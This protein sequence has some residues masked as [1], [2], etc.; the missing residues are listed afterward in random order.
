[1]TADTFNAG[2]RRRN[3]SGWGVP[4]VSD[5]HQGG[6]TST[7][8]V[9]GDTATF[10]D[11]GNLY[12]GVFNSTRQFT[13]L[14]E[15]FGTVLDANDAALSV[16][17]LGRGDVVGTKLWETPWFRSS[18]GARRRIREDVRQ[19]Q[20]GEVVSGERAIVGTTPTAHS[21]SIRPILDE[22][23]NAVFL[24]VEAHEIPETRDVENPEL[25]PE[26]EPG[27]RERT[28]D[29]RVSTTRAFSSSDVRDSG[30]DVRDFERNRSVPDSVEGE[31]HS[32]ESDTAGPRGTARLLERIGA[33]ATILG[34]VMA[35]GYA[36]LFARGTD[37]IGPVQRQLHNYFGSR[38][39]EPFANLSPDPLGGLVAAGLVAVAGCCLLLGVRLGRRPF[40]EREIPR[41]GNNQ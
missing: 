27:H 38:W 39:F 7:S 35:T 16:G 5:R 10:G 23:G 34:T 9:P 8:L 33:V 25:E 19:A 30:S 36:W 20:D 40:S 17:N 22:A 26:P 3:P 37:A 12:E 15:H 31:E 24:V 29:D 13:C 4:T 11:A 1:M 18:A 6:V 14:L 28:S 32:V 2:T 21:V 41:V